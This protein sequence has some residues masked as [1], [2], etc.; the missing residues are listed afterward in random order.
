VRTIT[1]QEILMNKLLVSTAFAS[2]VVFSGVAQAGPF[3]GLYVFGDSLSDPGN[4]S[5]LTNGAVPAGGSQRF[6][7]GPTA[8]EQLATSL[9]LSATAQ[10]GSSAGT[11]YAVGGAFSGQGNLNQGVASILATTGVQSQIARFDAANFSY[12]SSSTLFVLNGGANDLFYLLATG[13]ASGPALQTTAQQAAANIAN[14]IKTL[15]ADGARQFFVPNL[16]DVGR[17]PAFAGNPQGAGAASFY[18]VTYDNELALQLNNLRGNALYTG[19]NIRLFDSFSYLN[20]V[21]ASPSTY[22]ITNTTGQCSTLVGGCTNAG[23]TYLF[24][25]SVH[26]TQFASSR[27]AAA[28]YEAVVPTPGTLALIISALG[29]MGFIRSRK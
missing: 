12:N 20:T 4:A 13:G 26:P 17:T 2:L 23:A 24:W 3:T 22:G 21:L 5:A 15:Y 16:A 11:N 8:V 10:Y 1:T 18:S 6:S 27:T 25:D 19:I 7:N 14:G 9:G 28:Y 29:L